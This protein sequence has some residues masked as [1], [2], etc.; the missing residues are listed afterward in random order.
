MHQGVSL[1]Y[2]VLAL[3]MSHGKTL[4]CPP[5]AQWRSLLL[6]NLH[7][8]HVARQ[9]VAVPDNSTMVLFVANILAHLARQNVAVT[10]SIGLSYLPTGVFRFPVLFIENKFTVIVRY[11]SSNSPLRLCKQLWPQKKCCAA[12]YYDLNNSVPSFNFNQK[13]YFLIFEKTL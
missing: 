13:C 12:V 3:H 6:T 4:P 8:R 10:D 11:A 1:Y 7:T 2:N 9:T 5:T